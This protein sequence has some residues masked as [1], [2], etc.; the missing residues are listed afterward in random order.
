[1]YQIYISKAEN[2]SGYSVR[3][4]SCRHTT[5]CFVIGIVAISMLNILNTAWALELASCCSVVIL[6]EVELQNIKTLLSVAQILVA[7]EVVINI[8]RTHNGCLTARI[9]IKTV[10]GILGYI[11]AESILQV[12]RWATPAAP[13]VTKLVEAL[14]HQVAL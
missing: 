10:L 5:L 12:G 8:A 2:M 1:M 14:G 7:P 11:I 4:T 3:H 6:I 13:A 9:Y